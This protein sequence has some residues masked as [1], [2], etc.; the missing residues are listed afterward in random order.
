VLRAIEAEAE[1]FG[2]FCERTP[3]LEFIPEP[4]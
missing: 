4:A 1:S 2:R 3:T